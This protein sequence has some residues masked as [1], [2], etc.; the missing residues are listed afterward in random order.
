MRTAPSL[1]QVHPRTSGTPCID[2]E[3]N[4]DQLP[5]TFRIGQEFF[6]L[7]YV[8]DLL[9]AEDSED[10]YLTSLGYHLFTGRK[11]LWGYGRGGA[12]VLV[13]WHPNVEGRILVFP[14]IGNKETDLLSELLKEMPISPSG[15]QI[16][17]VSRFDL[18]I[19]LDLLKHI[20]NAAIMDVTSEP[21]QVLD[22]LYPSHIIDTNVVAAARHCLLRGVR[23]NV[24]RI[25]NINAEVLPLHSVPNYE[26]LNSVAMRWASAQPDSN[27]DDLLSPY[28]KLLDM[29]LDASLGL[30]G[31][32][33]IIDGKI[34][35]FC[36][37]EPP[38]R[39]RD[40][41][42]GLATLCNPS[43]SGLSDYQYNQMCKT[44][45][46]QGIG[47]L[48]LGGSE[49]AGLDRFKRKFKP[50]KSYELCSI[51]INYVHQK[52]NASRMAEVHHLKDTSNV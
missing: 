8:K 9:A 31:Q 36:I 37:W 45:H 50:V 42:T 2:W 34:E 15:A 17:R 38:A 7:Q 16:A 33:I 43:I 47:Q 12:L 4:F 11:G 27:V 40:I 35:A 30:D 51:N 48:N 28:P 44:L 41:A 10:S 26:D 5:D 21:E 18:E 24:N 20:Q 49:T 23:K 14:Q 52:M 22:W 1:T 29:A 25:Q 46:K 13:C 39:G 32:A 6:G 19:T 3:I